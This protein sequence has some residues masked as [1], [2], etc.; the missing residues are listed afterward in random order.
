MVGL[1]EFISDQH[2]VCKGCVMGKYTKIAFPSSD[3]RSKG[4]LDLI[5]SDVY[6]PISAV[7]IGVFNFHVSFIDNYFKKTWTYFM[8]AKDDV[9][10]RFQE[11]KALMENQTGKRIKVLRSENGGE[12]AS[13]EFV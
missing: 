4:I 13:I 8:K 9:F 6:G 3:S 1:P 11:F 5:H 12:Y 7:S 2:G 10:N